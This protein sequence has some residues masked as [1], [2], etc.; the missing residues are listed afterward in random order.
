MAG[1]K[2]RVRATPINIAGVMM[3][4]RPAGLRA[5]S[6]GDVGDTWSVSP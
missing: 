4:A 2:T 1:T 5:D 6:A 3:S